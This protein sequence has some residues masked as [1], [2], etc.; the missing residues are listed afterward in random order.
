MRDFSWSSGSVLDSV[1]GV[2]EGGMTVLRV[3]RGRFFFGDGVM[4]VESMA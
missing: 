4:L 3:R 2:L 1:F